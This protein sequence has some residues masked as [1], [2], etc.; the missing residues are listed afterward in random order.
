MCLKISIISPPSGKFKGYNMN[1]EEEQLS[2]DDLVTLLQ[3]VDH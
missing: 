1:R 3:S 2:V